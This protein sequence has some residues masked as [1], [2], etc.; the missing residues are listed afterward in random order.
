MSRVSREA[1]EPREARETITPGLLLQLSFYKPLTLSENLH[2]CHLHHHI[3]E[4]G[5][6]HHSCAEERPE[7]LYVLVSI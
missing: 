6:Y 4:H 7:A 3:I 1:R 2:S 5:G